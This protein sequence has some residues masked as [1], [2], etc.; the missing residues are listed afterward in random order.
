VGCNCIAQ[1]DGA[2]AGDAALR[3]FDGAGPRG[4]RLA[5]L[6]LMP[7][8]D[9]PIAAMNIHRPAP[10]ARGLLAAG[11]LAI[12][13]P[14]AAPV[15]ADDD[16]RKRGR[17]HG[18]RESKQEYQDGPCKVMV[19]H[20]AGGDFKHERKCQGLGEGFPERKEEFRQGPCKVKREWKKNG[21]FMEERD[22]EGKGHGAGNPHRGAPV[23][24]AP[25][26]YPPWVIADKGEPVYRPGREPVP[27][28]RAPSG[29]VRRCDSEA[30]GRVLGGIAGAVIGNQ[31]GK[32]SSNR[33]AA[34][35]GG[36]I[37]GVLI[38]G[39]IG[40]GIDRDNQ[41]CIGHALEFGAVGQRVAWSDAGTQYAVVPGRAVQRGERYC[42]PYEAEVLTPAGW[43]RTRG[44]ACRR[45]DGVWLTA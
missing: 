23:V 18:Q 19:E 44:T 28:P 33:G 6:Q 8:G 41:A 26:V 30:V 10:T 4:G 35:V 12:A 11:F 14:L 13:L 34:T 20:K 31:I 43:Q 42:R 45:G 29:D 21:D 7:A 37:V 24:V 2:A 1:A 36:A 38:G 32:D 27:A 5:L 15:L 40:R 25:V 22:C 39:E 3:S 9:A 17:H 16:D